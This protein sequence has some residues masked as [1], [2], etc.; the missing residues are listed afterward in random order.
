MRRD[1][2]DDDDDDH[3]NV[4]LKQVARLADGNHTRGPR[5]VDTVVK[6]VD[7]ARVDNLLPRDVRAGNAANA[8]R[9]SKAGR[10]SRE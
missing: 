9:T 5:V 10:G 3:N 6:V 7:T 1:H 2:P 4:R 8:W